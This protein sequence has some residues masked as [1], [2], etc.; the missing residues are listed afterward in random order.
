MISFVEILYKHY[1]ISLNYTCWVH[2]CGNLSFKHHHEL[3]YEKNCFLFCINL[4][5][6]KA[7]IR[8][9]SIQA[10]LSVIIFHCL[11]SFLIQNTI[12]MIFLVSIAFSHLLVLHRLAC[13]LPHTG[14]QMTRLIIQF[15]I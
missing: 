9:L 4:R 15:Q 3:L 6:T 1:A 10:D 14:F 8:R 2:V 5:K 12:R 11:C 7:H 13:V